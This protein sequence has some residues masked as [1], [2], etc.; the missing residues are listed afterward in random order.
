MGLSTWASKL[1]EEVPTGRTAGRF[2]FLLT[3][4][5]VPTI[6]AIRAQDIE[7]FLWWSALFLVAALIPGVII[8]YL[9]YPAHTRSDRAREVL[10][11]VVTAIQNAEEEKRGK[12]TKIKVRIERR[13]AINK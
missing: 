13:K 4:V 1:R 2:W 9:L 5:V 6:L 3:P 8:G 12:K 10:E 11:R 7:L